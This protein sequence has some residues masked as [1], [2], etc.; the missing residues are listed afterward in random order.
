VRDSASGAISA[1]VKSVTCVPLG[2]G[3]MEAKSQTTLNSASQLTQQVTLCNAVLEGLKLDVVGSV[4]GVNSAKSTKVALEFAQP[5]LSASA[6][7][8]VFKG[9]LLG[10][11]VAARFRDFLLGGEISYDVKQGQ[12]DKY[13]AAVAFDRPREKVVVQA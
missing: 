3:K 9:P 2:I 6:S 5:M 11:D 1:E 7:V 13:S 4:Q 10:A 12:I 8:D